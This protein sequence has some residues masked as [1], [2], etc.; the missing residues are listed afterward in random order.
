MTNRSCWRLLGMYWWAHDRLLHTEL[1]YVECALWVTNE[2]ALFF[3]G[4]PCG[5]HQRSTLRCL[6]KNKH[7][8]RR[9]DGI[10]SSVGRKALDE[11]MEHTIIYIHAEFQEMELVRSAIECFLSGSVFP[12][13]CTLMPGC[14]CTR[15]GRTAPPI[16]LRNQA[17]ASPLFHPACHARNN[18]L[19]IQLDLPPHPP[20]SDFHHPNRA[21]PRG[22]VYCGCAPNPLHLYRK[23]A[24][25]L[26]RVRIDTFPNK[27]QG[28]QPQ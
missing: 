14:R 7:P 21:P 5:R 10:T 15:R 20:T 27:G 17:G 26:F 11:G 22:W 6:R 8:P 28:L 24:C 18:G 25:C 4:R 16:L 2:C 9:C 13:I 3:R 19:R 12:R 23:A 1:T